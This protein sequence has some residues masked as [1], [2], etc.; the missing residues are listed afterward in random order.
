MQRDSGALARKAPRPVNLPL[1]KHATRAP[2]AQG[3]TITDQAPSVGK[4]MTESPASPATAALRTVKS[5]HTITIQ[6]RAAAKT[7]KSRYSLPSSTCIAHLLRFVQHLNHE[8][9]LR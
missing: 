8:H 5:C 6:T 9:L 1:V 7:P 4:L 3:K 2:S